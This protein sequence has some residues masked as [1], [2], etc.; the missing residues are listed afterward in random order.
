MATQPLNEAEY[1]GEFVV[2]NME[3]QHDGSQKLSI[4]S[5]AT[6]YLNTD[7][8]S[9]VTGMG[10]YVMVNNPSSGAYSNGSGS[11]QTSEEVSESGQRA[12]YSPPWTPGAAYL[13]DR[14]PVPDFRLPGQDILHD[15]GTQSM[16]APLLGMNDDK[17][18]DPDL[19]TVY[20]QYNSYAASSSFD[21]ECP[22]NY[23]YQTSTTESSS[24]LPKQDVSSP[25]WNQNNL[26]VPRY[27]PAFVA[28]EGLSPEP[29]TLKNLAHKSKPKRNSSQ[30]KASSRSS[31]L[32]RV[33]SRN[34]K[35]V[36]PGWE[37]IVVGEGGPK[38]VRERKDDEH[39]ASGGRRK[40]K[41]EKKVKEK[42]AR[43]RKVKACWTCWL[44]KVPVSATISNT[45]WCGSIYHKAFPSA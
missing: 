37:H 6:T 31:K 27:D 28:F 45:F 25:P 13:V 38:I 44:L 11:N 8:L 34:E 14:E 15:L 33:P 20:G 39:H 29:E 26:R 36:S 16:F 17:L 23:T 18:T 12:D 2:E 24:P 30:K 32:E 40:G 35:A 1:W 19:Q 10:G 41:L 21:Q 3:W 43:V 4:S 22:G 42:A 7:T 9:G 5:V